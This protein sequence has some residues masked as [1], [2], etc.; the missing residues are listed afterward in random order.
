M[1]TSRSLNRVDLIGNLT[2]DPSMKQLPN[3]AYITTFGMATNKNWKT[4]DGKIQEKAEY[5][6]I[7]C[8]NKLAEIC[9]NLLSLGMLVYIE[10]EITSLSWEENGVKMMRYEI[11]A[12]DMKLLDNKEKKGVGMEKALENGKTAKELENEES[13]PE[14]NPEASKPVQQ[15]S[16]QGSNQAPKAKSNPQDMGNPLDGA[17]P[18]Q[19]HEPMPMLSDLAELEIPDDKSETNSDS[20]SNDSEPLF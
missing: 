14:S 5:H 8:W 18:V 19:H 9:S 2:R 11:R 15:N 4:Q 6:N 12:S 13:M 17:S 7:V 16:N 20:N 10:G 3:G 1:A